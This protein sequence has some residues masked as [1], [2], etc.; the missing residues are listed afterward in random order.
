MRET[1][2]R[3]LAAQ[4][5]YGRTLLATAFAD[6]AADIRSLAAILMTT[7]TPQGRKLSA[8]L[9]Q[10]LNNHLAIEQD[11]SVRETIQR[12]LDPSR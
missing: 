7:P 11:Y 2:L 12:I 1:I 9:R 3:A 4:G 6:P 5:D 10:A 8:P